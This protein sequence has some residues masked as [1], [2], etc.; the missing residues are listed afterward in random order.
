MTKEELRNYVETQRSLN[1]LPYH[2]YTTLIDVIDTLEQE[3]RV[4]AKILIKPNPRDEYD[5]YH[6]CSNCNEVLPIYY[7]KLN[8]CPNCGADMREVQE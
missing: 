5:T 6:Y 1:N 7:D 8:Y 3:P 4:H 2:V